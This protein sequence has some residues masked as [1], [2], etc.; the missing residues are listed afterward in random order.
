MQISQRK[1]SPVCID[2]I[3]SLDASVKS[4]KNAKKLLQKAAEISVSESVIR[5]L[6]TMV[7][8]ELQ[9]ELVEQ[10]E[11]HSKG[12]LKPEKPEAPNVVS[13]APDGGRIFTRESNRGRGVHNSGWKETKQACLLTLSSEEREQDPHPELPSC[14][15]NQKHVEKVVREVH[16]AS[17]GGPGHNEEDCGKSGVS[18][19]GKLSVDDLSLLAPEEDDQPQEPK[20]PKSDKPEWRPKKL[21]RTGI[22]TMA[23]SDDFGPLLAGEAQR[24]GFYDAR[25][26]AFLGDGLGWNWSIHKKHFEDFV[27]ILDFIHPVGYIYKAAQAMAPNNYWETYIDMLTKCW[28]GNVVEVIETLNQWLAAQ[29]NPEAEDEKSPYRII[30]TCATYLSNNQ[31]RMNYPEYRRRGLP[32]STSS[33]ESL[34]KE[35][36]FRTKGTEKSWDRDEG[37]GAILTVRNAALRDDDKLS[38]WILNRPGSPSYRPQKRPAATAI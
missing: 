17:V 19:A 16:S 18:G 31:S 12:T 26:R 3:V 2:K 6:S 4:G 32:C 35:V 10:A 11:Q 38:D 33:V 14:F 25:R 23:S 36:N 13:V 24:R 7:G 22:A 8:L 37:A 34:I 28:Q 5:D 9:S 30:S 15:T 1:F 21:M 29:T 27:P 20:R